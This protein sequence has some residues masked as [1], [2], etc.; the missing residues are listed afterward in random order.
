[1][2]GRPH[3]PCFPDPD[4]ELVF[5][6]VADA[7]A[8][9]TRQ[10]QRERPTAGCAMKHQDWEAL[11]VPRMVRDA[12][13]ALER[14]GLDPSAPESRERLLANVRGNAKWRWKDLARQCGRCPN[15]GQVHLQD[16]SVGAG[17]PLGEVLDIEGVTGLDAQRLVIDSSGIESPLDDEREIGGDGPTAGDDGEAEEPTPREAL[18]A[19]VAAVTLTLDAFSSRGAEEALA[20]AAFRCD[21]EGRVRS[22]L[23]PERARTS[24]VSIETAQQHVSRAARTHARAI[25]EELVSP[26]G[27]LAVL[28]NA[29][30]AVVS[31]R[32]ATRY[33]FG[34]L[35]A[36]NARS[37]SE[38]RDN[39]VRLLA[40]AQRAGCDRETLAG[41][42]DYADVTLNGVGSRTSG[43]G[44][45]WLTP[46]EVTAF[47]EAA[48]K[49]NWM[50]ART[51]HAL[52]TSEGSNTTSANFWGYSP[53]VA[54]T[55]GGRND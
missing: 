50:R 28:A 13:R 45:R 12:W 2:S 27:P 17:D 26:D 20:A 48:M 43:R 32:A 38:D 25:L 8:V 39:I 1:M 5:F 10:L 9:A 11:A 16:N 14:R 35:R 22:S 31:V 19:L 6:A 40:R 21:L 33:L 41:L 3:S 7:Y 15:R 42:C 18:D 53:A 44:R 36:D 49:D 37:D 30:Y 52:L 23:A 47:A 4:E 46:Q 29:P 55:R 51:Q 24:R 54:R 34:E